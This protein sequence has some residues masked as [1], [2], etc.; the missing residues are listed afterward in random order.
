MLGINGSRIISGIQNIRF[1]SLNVYNKIEICFIAKADITY[2]LRFLLEILIVKGIASFK[3]K[4]EIDGCIGTLN[5]WQ[6]FIGDVML[7][8]CFIGWLLVL[9]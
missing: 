1:I 4:I 3:K 7:R 9:L 2:D 6:V 8:W 5:I